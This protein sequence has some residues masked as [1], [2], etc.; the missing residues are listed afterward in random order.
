MMYVRF[1]GLVSCLFVLAC[2]GI[3]Q[4]AVTTGG[5]GNTG[6]ANTS[7]GGGGS[8]L[9]SGTPAPASA[10][11]SRRRRSWKAA[12]RAMQCRSSGLLAPA[13]AVG[14]AYSSLRTDR[15]SRTTGCGLGSASPFRRTRVSTSSGCTR[16]I[17]P[18]TWSSTRPTTSTPC[19]RTSGW[20][21]RRTRATWRSP[22]PY[23]ARPPEA[24]RCCS[25]ARPA[26]QSPPPRP[27]ARWSTGRR[28][29]PRTARRS[30]VTRYLWF[31]R[32]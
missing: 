3:K 32:R 2:A 14:P 8:G 16:Q 13:R 15:C 26:S 28:R 9:T 23:G 24:V 18:T 25:G 22:S 6:T 31:R 19:A 11:I 7:G 17:R 21:W 4:N 5:G 1:V 29:A 10:R 27:P 12:P 20:P 30:R